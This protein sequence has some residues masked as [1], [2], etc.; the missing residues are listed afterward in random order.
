MISFRHTLLSM[1]AL[2][3]MSML[4][5]S[6]HTGLA[7]LKSPVCFS[8]ETVGKNHNC[9]ICASSLGQLAKSS[10]VPWAHHENSLSARAHTY[11]SFA[12]EHAPH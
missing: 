12:S 8:D 11:P 10:S 4:A 2:A 5:L 7:A 1:H 6:L 9:P 3:P